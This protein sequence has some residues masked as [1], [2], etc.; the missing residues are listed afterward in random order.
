MNIKELIKYKWIYN[1]IF[2]EL[3]EKII[4]RNDI[5]NEKD[6]LKG[7]WFVDVDLIFKPEVDNKKFKE[8]SKI[9]FRFYETWKNEN[10]KK[11]E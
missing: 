8:L 1:Q 7:L 5:E 2:W 6:L 9:I 11:E 4:F 3:L 10:S